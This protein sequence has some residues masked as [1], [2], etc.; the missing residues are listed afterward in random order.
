MREHDDPRSAANHLGRQ[1]LAMVTH[2]IKRYLVVAMVAVMVVA[3]G[4]PPVAPLS[5]ASSVPSESASASGSGEAETESVL[6]LFALDEYAQMYDTTFTTANVTDMRAIRYAADYVYPVGMDVM[7]EE[8]GSNVII[9]TSFSFDLSKELSRAELDA[10][11]TWFRE[12]KSHQPEAA[13]WIEEQ[14]GNYLAAPG[15]AISQR[16]TFGAACAGF[17]TLDPGQ[18]GDQDV[19]DPYFNVATLIGYFV[20]AADSDLTGC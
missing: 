13:E 20:N 3:C 11:E 2:L 17:F 18:F 14:L 19:T 4:A 6:G 9:Q 5:P 1:P 8:P 10:Q 7:V 16:E 15:A 12:T